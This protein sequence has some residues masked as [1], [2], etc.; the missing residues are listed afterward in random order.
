[1]SSKPY[2]FRV[3]KIRKQAKKIVKWPN[4]ILA[5][6]IH[7][8]YKVSPFK[9]T[10]DQ[11]FHFILPENKW[12]PSFSGVFRGCKMGT[13]ARYG[14]IWLFWWMIKQETAKLIHGFSK[15]LIMF[16]LVSFKQSFTSKYW[17]LESFSIVL[18]ECE[19]F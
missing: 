17:L 18:G 8:R 2:T 19:S 6:I 11:C 16:E 15:I 14:L 1:M 10:S 12:K 7:V 4:F 5:K 9:P 3:D 13:L